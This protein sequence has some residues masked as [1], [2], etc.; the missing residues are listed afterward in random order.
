MIEQ[1]PISETG[2]IPPFEQIV[3]GMITVFGRGNKIFFNFKNPASKFKFKGKSE[4][5][6]LTFLKRLQTMRISPMRGPAEQ[7]ENSLTPLDLNVDI[8]SAIVLAVPTNSNM[9]FSTSLPA[10]TRKDG[11]TDAAYS[12][13]RYVRLRSGQ[14][15]VLESQ[16][17]DGCQAV[18]FFA[19]QPSQK[20]GHGFNMHI[21]I[22]QETPGGK[23]QLLPLL[24]DPDVRNPGGGG[25]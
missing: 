6:L 3:F 22:V 15:P 19:K 10:V 8:P 13:L 16:P 2:A 17:F 5:S 1:H 14:S 12:D 23:R 21:D 7:V 4:A 11:T 20:Y 24:I 9:Q 25:G 18:V